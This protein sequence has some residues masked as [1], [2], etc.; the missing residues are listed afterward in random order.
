MSSD[1]ILD[2]PDAALRSTAARRRA[3]IHQCTSARQPLANP[4]WGRDHARHQRPVDGDDRL[5]CR[6]PH[7]A[8]SISSRS[9]ALRG[10]IGLREG[11]DAGTLLTLEAAAIVHDI[12]IKVCEDQVRQLQRQAARSRG[13]RPSPRR[14]WGGWALARR[15]SSGSAIWW[16][17]TTPTRTSTAPITRSWW[18]RDFLVNLYE[19]GSARETCETVLRNIFRTASG[20]AIC[21]TM[22]L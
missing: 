6:R 19:D 10:W 13:P 7:G 12:G 21:K 2:R 4:Q 14:C 3:R 20:T 9:T 11:L 5:R 18:R 16:A 22:F 8:F 15:W 17:T 1:T